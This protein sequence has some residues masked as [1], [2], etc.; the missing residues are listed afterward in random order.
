M[1]EHSLFYSKCHRFFLLC[2]IILILF[3]SFS[4]QNYAQNEG[5]SLHGDFLS[6]VFSYG[7][8]R[9]DVHPGNF[10]IGGQYN[11]PI[12]S[13][14]ELNGGFDFLWVELYGKINSVNRQAE[15]FMPFIFG[16]AA[17]NLDQW[18]IFGKIGISLDES[19]NIIGTRQGWVSSILS[20]YMG[21][22]QFGIKC[23][24]DNVL[25]ISTSIGYYFGDKI[26]IDN[27]PL[28]FATVN[29]GFSYNLF[30]PAILPQ[31]IEKGVDEYKDK[32]YVI[33]SENAILNRKVLELTDSIKSLQLKTPTVV[34][35]EPVQITVPVTIPTRSIS[36]DSINQV[37]NLHL[38]EALNLKDFINRKGLKEEGELILE[39]YNS[40]AASFKG[41]QSGIYLICTVSDIKIFKKYE[42]EF[43]RIK[44]QSIPSVKNKLI[45]DINVSA[46]ETNNKIKLIIK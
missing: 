38:R 13:V 2:T 1:L 44:F 39:E 15:V 27:T 24:L 16:G 37:Y 18:R 29:M 41:F 21:F 11:I 32:Y 6:G 19:I 45:M 33:Q 23:P 36:I 14:V 3:V 34:K 28:T 26:K 4:P 7:F 31:V 30:S 10:L 8:N 25:S 17:L 12:V 42:S 20:D 43:P 35:I 22:C 9:P 40:I 46:T 5:V